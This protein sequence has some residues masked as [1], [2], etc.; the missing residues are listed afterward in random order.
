M[1]GVTGPEVQ[2]FF[3]HCGGGVAHTRNSLTLEKSSGLSSEDWV[4]HRIR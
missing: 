4:E 2:P 1:E 3:R